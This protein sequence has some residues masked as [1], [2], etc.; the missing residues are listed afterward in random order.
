MKSILSLFVCL[1]A[2]SSCLAIT[3]YDESALGDL[4]GVFGSPTAIATS[5]GANTIIGQVG[6]NGNTGATDGTDADYFTF[7]VPPAAS[8]TSISV[9][10]YT[11]SPSNPGRSFAA[12]TV[13]NAFT[14]QGGGDIDGSTLFNAGTVGLFGSA[15]PL[16]PGTYSIW[17]QETTSTMVDYQLTINQT[18]P[19]PEPAGAMLLLGGIAT[20]ALRRRK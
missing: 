20:A 14:G 12:F 15:M 16:G 7:E 13:G 4:S 1:F 8:V 5:A 19:V 18:V 11:F 10:S 17:I 9:D 6:N 2:S 3:V